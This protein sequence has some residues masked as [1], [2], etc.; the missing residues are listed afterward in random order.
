MLFRSCCSSLVSVR[1]AGLKFARFQVVPPVVVFQVARSQQT[2]QLTA[3]Q[4]M[5]KTKKEKQKMEPDSPSLQ[6]SV[7]CTV[8]YFSIRFGLLT[9][10]SVLSFTVSCFSTLLFVICSIPR[11]FSCQNLHLHRV[12][13]IYSPIL[14][15]HMSLC[16]TTQPCLGNGHFIPLPCISMKFSPPIS[17]FV[18]HINEVHPLPLYPT[19]SLDTV[20]CI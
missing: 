6:D 16:L 19:S 4:R 10:S 20:P 14:C 12:D 17:T 2:R 3:R 9:L 5:A 18:L 15:H 11:V 13:S 1:G 8:P 7:S